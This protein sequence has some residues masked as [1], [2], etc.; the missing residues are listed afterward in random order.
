MKVRGFLL[1]L[2]SALLTVISVAPLTTA[3]EEEKSAITV[4]SGALTPAPRVSEALYVREMV[5]NGRETKDPYLLIEAAQLGITS[6][7]IPTIKA[8]VKTAG[9]T[10]EKTIN[11]DP[12]ALLKEAAQMA[13]DSAD[14][15]AIQIAAEIARNKTTGLGN[16][17]LADEISKTNVSRGLMRNGPLNDRGCL[18]S[19]EVVYW[20]PEFRKHEEAG[21]AV[22][23]NPSPIVLV[24]G[25]ERSGDVAKYDEATLKK[26]V[27]WYMDRGGKV[28]IAVGAAYGDTCYEIY[29]P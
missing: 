3:Q 16:D 24:I 22:L 19:G 4:K 18:N 25:D 5:I 7:K 11:V 20:S 21:V 28:V 1:V 12:P 29:V 13:G 8:Q 26:G 6:A 2:C 10:T 27:T 14:R 17:A 9:R 23:S 15:Q